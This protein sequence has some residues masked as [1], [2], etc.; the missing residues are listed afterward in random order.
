[1]YLDEE[2]AF[3][4]IPRLLPDDP[5]QRSQGWQVI[6]QVLQASGDLPPEGNDRIARVRQ[7]FAATRP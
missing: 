1:L 7:L 4:A 6:E 5:E 2:R 3:R